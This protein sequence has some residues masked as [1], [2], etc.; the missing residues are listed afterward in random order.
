M[1]VSREQEVKKITTPGLWSI[2]MNRR[3]KM[4]QINRCSLGAASEHYSA[5][6]KQECVNN[7]VNERQELHK[8]PELCLE[9]EAGALGLVRKTAEQ[10]FQSAGSKLSYTSRGPW[11]LGATT[12]ECPRRA[13]S[14]R[15]RVSMYRRLKDHGRDRLT[16]S[17]HGHR[18][19]VSAP[20]QPQP[21]HS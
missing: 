13:G 2:K 7:K 10:T 16:F 17:V 8:L 9:V 21:R 19:Q 18:R 3:P 6:K 5:K 1:R 14:I 12:H 4:Q 20:S 11:R 15:R